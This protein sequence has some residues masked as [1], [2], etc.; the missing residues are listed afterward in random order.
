MESNQPSNP[1]IILKKGIGKK[2]W[3]WEISCSEEK[4]GEELKKIVPMLEDI[5]KDMEK[6]FSIKYKKEDEEE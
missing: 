2:Q 6:A 5:N 1:R 3:G 4:D